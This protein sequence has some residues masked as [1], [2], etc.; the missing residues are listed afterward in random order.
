MMNQAKRK[1]V[2]RSA[3][4]EVANTWWWLGCAVIIVGRI[5]AGL[6]RS[7]GMLAFPG[8]FA[9]MY[10]GIIALGVVATVLLYLRQ[11]R[12]GSW[13][14]MMTAGLALGTAAAGASGPGIF[15]LPGGL[16]LGLGAH[17]LWAEAK[18]PPPAPPLPGE[19]RGSGTTPTPN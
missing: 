18:S 12:A 6:A 17:K 9:Q 15:F 19:G 16:L 7:S 10:W 3:R 5:G 14:A 11:R 4:T 1:P 2:P 13:A 8:G